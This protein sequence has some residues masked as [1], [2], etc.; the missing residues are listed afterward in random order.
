MSNQVSV[1]PS[2][3]NIGVQVAGIAPVWGKISGT[4]SDQDDLQAEFDTVDARLDKIELGPVLVD[5]L[6][7]LAI[8]LDAGVYKLPENRYYFRSSINF[9]VNPIE[10]IT[11][12]GDYFFTANTAE[13]FLTYTGT[14][15]FITTSQTDIVMEAIG[16][17]F[18]NTPNAKCIDMANGNS[19]ISTLVVYVAATVAIDLDAF[20]FL[21]LNDLPII[22]CDDGIIANDVLTITAKLPQFN[23]GTNITGKFLTASGEASQR[24]LM[25][26]IDSRPESNESFIDIQA[27]YGGLIDLNGGVHTQGGGTFFSATSRDHTDN[28]MIVH[29]IQNAE[30]S[31]ATAS[32]HIAVGDEAS[33]SVSDGNQ[34]LIAGTYTPSLVQ[35]FVTLN[36]R[37]TY[38]G[39][40][41]TIFGFAFK[42]LGVPASGNNRIYQFFIRHT[43]FIG[44]VVTLIPISFDPID[45]DSGTP[46]KAICIGDISMATDD[47]LE[48]VVIP[49]GNSI[50]ITCSGLSFIV[51]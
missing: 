46:Q 30:E 34:S 41:T 18:F 50:A 11:P 19:Y 25:S 1:G 23:S 15:S 13:V 2:G 35:N 37:L 22:G 21:T 7:D 4:L 48:P 45:V 51:G 8:F 5:S 49:Q 39:N 16:A 47:F 27:N 31:R 9:G 44:T 3:D 20:S 26:T 42:C 14:V 40:A 6:A 33:T 36:S 32:V 17:F 43:K 12:S 29:A 28:D 24:L 38:K 10:L